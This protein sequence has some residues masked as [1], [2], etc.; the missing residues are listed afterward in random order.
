M[1]NCLMQKLGSET[2]G[3]LLSVMQNLGSETADEL[4]SNAEAWKWDRRWVTVCNAE[5]RKW[6]PNQ[7]LSGSSDLNF[8]NPTITPLD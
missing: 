8:P 1:G 6:F 3:G 7:R 5:A 4:L 2:A